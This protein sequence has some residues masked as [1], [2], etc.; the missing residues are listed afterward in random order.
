M[1]SMDGRVFYYNDENY[2][3]GSIDWYPILVIGL[4]FSDE[5]GTTVLYRDYFSFNHQG[6]YDMSSCSNDDIKRLDL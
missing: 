4:H 6:K 5:Y 2:K 1:I 3:S